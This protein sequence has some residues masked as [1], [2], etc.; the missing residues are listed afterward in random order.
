MKRVLTTLSLVIC[1]LSLSPVRAEVDPNFYIYLCFGQSNMEGNAPEENM[2]KVTE[3]RFKLLATCNFSSPSRKMGQW[4]S[5]TPPL[6][7]PIGHLCPADYFG[8]TMIAALPSDVKIG[9]VPV[10]IGGCD[11]RMFDKDLYKT[12]ANKDDWSGQIARNHYGGNPYQRLIDMAKKAQEVGVIKGI[13]LHQGCTNN[14]DSNWPNMVKK[15]YT[16]ILKDLGLGTDSVPLFVGETLRQENGGACYG[17]NTQVARMPSVIPH[18]Y[19]IS[20]EGCP[21]NGSDPWHFNAL[22]YRI[23]G[24]RYALAALKDMGCELK[25]DGKYTLNSKLK[26]FYAAK[27]ITVSAGDILIPGQPIEV[28]ATFMDNHTENVSDCVTFRSDD[29]LVKDGKIVGE[30]TGQV[31]VIYDDFSGQQTIVSFT[32]HATYFPFTASYFKKQS[33]SVTV[34]VDTRSLQFA[35]TNA[36]AGWSYGNNIDFS[37]FKYLVVKLKEPQ[38]SGVEIRLSKKSGSSTSLGYKEALE[39][40]TVVAIDLDNMYYNKVKMDPSNVCKVVFQS[41][42]AGTLVIDDVFLTN[43]EQYA[44]YTGISSV[45]DASS[46]FQAPLYSLDGRLAAPK[47]LSPG[48]YIQQNKKVLIK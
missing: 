46:P 45:V 8:H 6:V 9:V 27:S 33:G 10:A 44:V 34:D 12:Y 15:I 1:Y 14:G 32:T 40:R 48:V 3:S 16:N 13:L 5:A 39:D 18:S 7:N 22:G 24:K 4:Y 36:Q 20:S 42:K 29:I 17:H 41:P 19:V 23:I 31:D 28:K 2:D 43:D 26:P 25:P 47:A 30:G 37:A 21:G 38:T 11:I 35:G